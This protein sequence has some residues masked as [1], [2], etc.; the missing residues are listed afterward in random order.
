MT[1]D[2]ATTL[3]QAYLG[4][5]SVMLA[6]HRLTRTPSNELTK[7]IDTGDFS[8]LLCNHPGNPDPG[9]TGKVG[10]K[11]KACPSCG[12]LSRIGS[13]T[14]GGMPVRICKACGTVVRTY[15]HLKKPQ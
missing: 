1:E 6:I 7:A 4:A 10:R 11:R 3:K 8:V 5:V 13:T 12:A 14:R 2:P 15:P 9:K